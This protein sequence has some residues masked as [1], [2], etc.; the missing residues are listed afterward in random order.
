MDLNSSQLSSAASPVETV[1]ST[2][3]GSD[4]GNGFVGN[5]KEVKGLNIC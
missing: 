4:K 2:G 3:Q 5:S 1:A